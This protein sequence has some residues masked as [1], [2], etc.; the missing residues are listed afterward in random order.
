MGSMLGYMVPSAPGRTLY[1]TT[2]LHQGSPPKQQGLDWRQRL[3]QLLRP[4]WVEHIMTHGVV[5]ADL[6]IAAGQSANR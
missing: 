6:A 2:I 4:A 1:F 3:Q 5:D